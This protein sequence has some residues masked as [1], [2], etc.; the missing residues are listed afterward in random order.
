MLDHIFVLSDFLSSAES[1][2]ALKFEPIEL[3][4]HFLTDLFNLWCNAHFRS[5]AYFILKFI[6]AALTKS[7]RS[8]VSFHWAVQNAFSEF[9][10]ELI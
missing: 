1:V 10:N 9:S 3:L 2:D 7:E 8:R 6:V 4:D 5:T